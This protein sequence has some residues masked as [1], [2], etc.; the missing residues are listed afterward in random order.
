MHQRCRCKWSRT[1]LSGRLQS[2][3]AGPS[4]V[5]RRRLRWPLG[6]AHSGRTQT[7]SWCLGHTMQS[8]EQQMERC[9]IIWLHN[10]LA[11]PGQAPISDRVVLSHI[12]NCISEWNTDQVLMPGPHDAEHWIMNE[13]MQYYM[14]TQCLGHFPDK[15]PY[16]TELR[17]ITFLI[18][19]L[20]GARFWPSVN[21]LKTISF[22]Y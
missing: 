22:C 6:S 19:F 18:S 1:E 12:P 7:G 11:F 8:T 17:S 9:N 20:G 14:I 3:Q 16:L 21:P 10:V 5:R 15:P 4:F 13:K 2:Q